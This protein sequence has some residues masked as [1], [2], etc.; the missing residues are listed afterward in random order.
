MKLIW[1]AKKKHAQSM[2]EMQR[3]NALAHNSQIAL[4][5][6]RATSQ[7]RGLSM[8]WETYHAF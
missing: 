3:S 7:S 5:I 2:C 4:K 8:I 6:I 1:Y